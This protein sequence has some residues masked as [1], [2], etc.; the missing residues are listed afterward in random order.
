MASEFFNSSDRNLMI[1]NVFFA[2][3]P[4]I[5]RPLDSQIQAALELLS[6]AERPIVIVGKG[7]AYSPGAAD[8]IKKFIDKTN[9]PFLA[10]PMGKG[11]VPD[12]DP[13]SVGPAR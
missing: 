11:C 8:L 6:K 3:R 7:A 13:N 1:K 5:T 4:T 10:T 2:I 12:S 9:L